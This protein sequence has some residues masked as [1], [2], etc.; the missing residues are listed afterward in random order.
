MYDEIEEQLVA[1]SDLLKMLS[2]RILVTN[3]NVNELGV[4]NLDC[5]TKSKKSYET[6]LLDL[7]VDELHFKYEDLFPIFTDG[8][9][10]VDDQGAAFYIPNTPMS[11]H[12][13]CY[14]IDKRVCILT[15]E[16]FAISE[17]ISCS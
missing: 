3:F 14:K 10:N 11:H 12:D 15:L 1:S 9:K 8:S 16:L 13:N 2:L 4:S 6:S 5:M 17:A 7:T